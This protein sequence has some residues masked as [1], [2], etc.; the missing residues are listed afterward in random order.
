M[1]IRQISL[2]S[3]GFI[4]SVFLIFSGLTLSVSRVS[5][6]TF[7]P[8]TAHAG[9]V[10][11]VIVA[12]VAVVAVVALAAEFGVFTPELFGVEAVSSM[13]GGY[14]VSA[15]GFE[16]ST[17]LGAFALEQA[18][19]SIAECVVGLICGSDGGNDGSTYSV[20][21]G[22]VSGDECY[23]PLNSCGKAY[24][25]TYKNDPAT[26]QMGCEIGGKF[27][28]GAPADSTCTG[29]SIDY[30]RIKND[31]GAG[32]VDSGQSVTLEWSSPGASYCKWTGATKNFK[33]TASGEFTIDGI[34]QTSTYQIDCA[35]ASDNYG[36]S[37]FVTVTVLEPEVTLS[38]DRNRVRAGDSVTAIWSAKDIQ[39]CVVT[40]LAGTV[41]AS[42]TGEK[43]Q[44]STGSPYSTKINVQN[45]FKIVCQTLGEPITKQVIVNVVPSYSDF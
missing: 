9:E 38:V 30:F 39:S 31:A 28:Y 20:S 7:G 11:E 14:F 25:G 1:H 29:P 8:S 36:L 37:K 16:S 21:A 6:I 3:L 10:L 18:V 27:D 17:A 41:L 13:E 22:A 5:P 15:L 23:G 4:I 12:V 35:D 40:N 45:V 43:R 44:F 24:K 34:T 19:T 42:G 2:A 32:T 33:V 26:G